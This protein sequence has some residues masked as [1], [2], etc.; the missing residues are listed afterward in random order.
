[1]LLSFSL[2]MFEGGI[3]ARSCN[4]PIALNGTRFVSQ[5]MLL[6]LPSA[7]SNHASV[8]PG[9][10]D[11]LLCWASSPC[12]DCVYQALLVLRNLAFC[13]ENHAHF[14]AAPRMLPCITRT[15]SSQDDHLPVAAAA[16]C[17]WTLAYHSEKARLDT[18][19][20]GLVWH[21]HLRLVSTGS[22]H[23]L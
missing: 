22:H 3:A 16:S 13:T 6:A 7:V 14:L 9:I 18:T 12:T 4:E 23:A 2:V 17:L 15:L 5:A 21:L 1:M 11:Q 20:P 8:C 10:G 19:A